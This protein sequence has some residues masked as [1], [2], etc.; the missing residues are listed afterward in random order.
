MK[1]CNLMI[2]DCFE[3]GDHAYIILD[4]DINGRNEVQAEDSIINYFFSSEEDVLPIAEK[5]FLIREQ[6]CDSAI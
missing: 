5:L 1:V 3:W 2:G 6:V 4:V